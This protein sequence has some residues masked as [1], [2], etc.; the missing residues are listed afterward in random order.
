MPHV[1]VDNLCWPAFEQDERYRRGLP[2]NFGGLAGSGAALDETLRTVPGRAEFLAHVNEL[3]Q[4]L[5]AFGDADSAAD[6]VALDF[7]A[8]RLPPASCAAEPPAG[9]VK[10]TGTWAM[11]GLALSAENLLCSVA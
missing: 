7:F 8:S 5:A 2:W 10:V 1:S 4:G 6:E 9:L 11:L 3:F